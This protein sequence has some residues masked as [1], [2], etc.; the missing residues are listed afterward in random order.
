MLK[1]K[2]SGGVGSPEAQTE[3]LLAEWMMLARH[4]KRVHGEASTYYRK[5]ADTSMI[6]K[7]EIPYKKGL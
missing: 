7:K 4:D 3:G 2:M 6:E 1:Q 5:W